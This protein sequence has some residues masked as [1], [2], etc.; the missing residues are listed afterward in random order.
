MKQLQQALVTVLGLALGVQLAAAWLKPAIPTL[1][2]LC[3]MG[4]L[5]RSLFVRRL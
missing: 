5:L 1:A 2:I 4:W 3:V